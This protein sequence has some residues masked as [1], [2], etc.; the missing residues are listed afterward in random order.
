M[1]LTANPPPLA[2]T[3]TFTTPEGMSSLPDDGRTYELVN[4]ELVEKSMSD[5]SQIVANNLMEEL[6]VWSRRTGAGRSLVEASFRCFPHAPDMVRRPDVCFLSAV[7]L[8]GYPW[9]Q[10]HFTVAPELA[11]EVVSPNDEVYELDQKI[12]DYFQAGVRLVW[13]VNPEL[14]IVRIHRA[15][16]NVSELV[17]DA[18]LDGENVLPGFRCSLPVLFARPGGSI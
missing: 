3:P 14:Q 4:G 6:V 5:L 12:R 16:G 18:V 8:A 9:G 15:P 2:A 7:Q 1:T 17:D 11:V 13:I 10:G